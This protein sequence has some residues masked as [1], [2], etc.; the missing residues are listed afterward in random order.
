MKQ[1]KKEELRRQLREEFCDSK[2]YNDLWEMFRAVIQNSSWGTSEFGG[3]IWIMDFSLANLKKLFPENP[4]LEIMEEEK[5]LGFHNYGLAKSELLRE[6]C[7]WFYYRAN[8]FVIWQ[9]LGNV[10]IKN[11]VKGHITDGLL[12]FYGHGIFLSILRSLAGGVV[13]TWSRRTMEIYKFSL[14][15][16]RIVEEENFYTALD[17]GFLTKFPCGHGSGFH[18]YKESEEYGICYKLEH[19]SSTKGYVI[20]ETQPEKFITLIVNDLMECKAQGYGNKADSNGNTCL[21]PQIKYDHYLDVFESFDQH[22]RSTTPI[23]QWKRQDGGIEEIK[24]QL[25]Q[26]APKHGE[27]WH[28]QFPMKQNWRELTE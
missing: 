18:Y 13:R 21:Y 23:F 12:S 2:E 20:S 7:D 6:F 24:I 3:P 15:E 17:G 9:G 25:P 19:F 8:K 28:R 5:A 16:A 1:I 27:F 26:I 14:R 4:W 11:E 22:F 10:L